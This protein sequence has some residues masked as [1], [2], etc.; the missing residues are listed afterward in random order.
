M[1]AAAEHSPRSSICGILIDERVCSVPANIVE[2]LDVP[3]LVPDQDEV[4]V[5]EF[6]AEVAS[7]IW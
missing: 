6:K 3:F 4:K 5:G 1:V 2:G 7:N